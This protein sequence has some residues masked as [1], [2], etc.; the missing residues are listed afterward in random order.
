MAEQG[1]DSKPVYKKGKRSNQARFPVARIKKLIQADEDVGKVAQATPVVVSKALELFLKALVD[2]CVK[3]ARERG[4]KKV[5][6]YGLKRV[7]QNVPTF[8]FCADIVAGVPDPISDETGADG[9]PKKKRAPRKKKEKEV[10]AKE[11]DEEDTK[12]GKDEDD[13]D[14]EE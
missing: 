14:Y 12:P 1:E 6:A 13:D 3:D 2:E 11:E 5:S 9:E 8:D 4:S 10:A 7:V